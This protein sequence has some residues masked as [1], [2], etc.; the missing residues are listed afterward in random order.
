MEKPFQ[1]TFP[2]R[3]IATAVHLQTPATLPQTLQ[4]LGLPKRRRV[5]VVIGGASKLST[6]DFNRVQLLFLEVLAPLAMKWGACVV[7][8]GTDAGVMRLMGQARSTLKASFPLVGVAP[9]GLAVLP[10]QIAASPDAAP[11]EENH[12]HF[13]LIPGSNW[14]DESPWIADVATALAEDQPSVAILINGGEVSWKD[15][16]QNVQEGRAIITI[17]GSGRTADIL[18]AVLRRQA[19]D[20]RAQE[21][22]KSGLVQAIDLT[23]GREELTKTIEMIF[24]GKE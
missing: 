14:G 22:I 9:V 19:D 15:A 17:A 24:A 6:E 18:A 11:L 5:L 3:A 7:D 4:E 12:T 10:G 20:Q 8:G 1:I 2:N 16:S 21:I 13:L 23:A